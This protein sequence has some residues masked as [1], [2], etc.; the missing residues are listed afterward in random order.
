MLVGHRYCTELWK[1][2]EDRRRVC[3]VD[4]WRKLHVQERHNVFTET[5]E[6]RTTTQI[7]SRAGNAAR[8][9]QKAHMRVS[10]SR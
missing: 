7:M 2:E 5:T 4:N 1:H 9:K 6:V 8:K 3:L 10:R